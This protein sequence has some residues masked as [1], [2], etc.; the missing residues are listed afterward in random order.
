MTSCF[1]P[2]ASLIPWSW[3]ASRTFLA[4][5]ILLSY[6]AWKREQRLKA[7]GRIGEG[8]VYIS[9]SALT[10]ISFYFFAF[11]PLPRAYYPELFFGRP[12]EFISAA[13]FLMALIGYLKKG[14][15]RQDPFENALVVSL[16]I[17]FIGQALFMS[18]SFGLFDAMF[19]AAHM[20]KVITYAVVLVGLQVNSFHLYRQADRTATDLARVNESLEDERNLQQALIDNLPDYIYVRTRLHDSSLLTRPTSSFWALSGLTMLSARQT[21]ISLRRELA[22]QYYRDEQEVL[23]SGSALPYKVE[24]T[25]DIE[26]SPSWVLTTK[27]PLKDAGRVH[28]A[29]RWN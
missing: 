13:L 3:N 8:A 19:D 7:A 25:E 23:R 16:V 1:R 4:L 17:G 21:L 29:P 11:V 20:L 2:P 18:R 26:G 14:T 6:W 12:E 9:V 5:L 27:I 10:L 24:E 22:E 15:W 28:Q